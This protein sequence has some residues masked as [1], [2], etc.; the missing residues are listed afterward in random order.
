[1]SEIILIVEESPE[2]RHEAHN[3]HLLMVTAWKNR[4]KILRRPLNVILKKTFLKWLD[5]T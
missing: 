1:M 5:Y 3:Q 2:G 4:K